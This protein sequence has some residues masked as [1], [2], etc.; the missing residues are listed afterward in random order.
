MPPESVELAGRRQ[1]FGAVRAAGR[2]RVAADRSGPASACWAVRR[3]A[4]PLDQ[5]LPE[6]PPQFDV[7]GGRAAG[8][9]RA[10]PD[11]RADRD[12]GAGRMFLC[13]D[14]QFHEFFVAAAS[15][16]KSGAGN[17]RNLLS[18]QAV[19]YGLNQRLQQQLGLQESALGEVLGPTV[20]S[21]VAMVGSDMFLREGAALGVLFEARS[22]LLLGQR[23]LQRQRERP[24]EGR[25]RG[26]GRKADAGR[27][28]RS[29]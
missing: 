16:W 21:D 12:A 23:T 26:Q 3:P 4:E 6:Q 22:A 27:Q 24:A 14:R 7:H 17:A 9:G 5:P 2:R 8:A 11:G 18:E 19:D 1:L 28:G 10:K 15:D 29:R 25:E 13:A 20:I